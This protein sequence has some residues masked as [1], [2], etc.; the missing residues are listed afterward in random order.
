MTQQH[1][2]RPL[3]QPG[4][5]LKRR[6]LLAA[7]WAAVAAIVAKRTTEPVAATTTDTNFVANGTATV[8]VDT[9]SGNFSTGVQAK[10]S[11][12][13]LSANGGTYGV[14][15][16]GS[17]T[18]MYAVG[19]IGAASL[20]QTYGF[21]AEIDGTVANSI[22]MFA[23]SL[24]SGAGSMG[25]R[26]MIH[27][28]SS[29]A[30]TIGVY[31]ENL[32]TNT[33]G[34]PGAGGYGV[35]GFSAHG[36]GVIGGTSG[37]GGGGVVGTAFGVPGVWAGLFFGPMAVVGG[38]KSAAVANGDGSHSLLYCMESPESWFEDF[39]KATLACGRAEV[40]IDPEFAAVA[41]LTDYHVFLSAS[42]HH[43]LAVT[44]QTPTRFRVEA[45]VDLARL[46]GTPESDLAGT[47]SWRLVAKRKDITAPRLAR[48]QLPPAPRH[49][50]L[51]GPATPL[52]PTHLR[53]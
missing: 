3:E 43:H 47:F 15:A 45:D 21:Q 1:S 52:R 31:G 42:D 17:N 5:G 33:G 9:F 36:H 29:A 18:G 10:G 37:P 53:G 41:D 44:E 28:F 4:G 8:G 22:G 26:G 46:K 12:A 20:G 14:F 51:P 27:N 35:Y 30:N 23:F 25:V 40:A 38:A 7:A 6:G 2:D 34:A 16:S 13:G 50:D 24:S 49:A 39:G 11:S 19:P 32:S 48:I